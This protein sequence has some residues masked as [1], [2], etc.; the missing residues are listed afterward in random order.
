LHGSVGSHETR[1]DRWFDDL[2]GTPLQVG[3]A[4]MCQMAEQRLE[5]GYV[6]GAVRVG[7]TVRRQAGPWTPAVHALLTYLADQGFTS[8]PRPLGFD[9]QT[10]RY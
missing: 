7:D 1:H 4:S 5:G 8:A 9:E 2:S 6:D 10:E 3:C